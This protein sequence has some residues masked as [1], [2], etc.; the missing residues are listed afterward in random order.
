MVRMMNFLVNLIHPGLAHTV[1]QCARFCDD[2]KASHESAVKS[3]V[4]Y[5]LSSREK[6][7]R[8]KPMYGLN[9]K[10]DLNRWLE[11]YVDASFAGDWNRSWSKEP[12]SMLSRIGFIVKN[13]NCP[14]IRTSKLQTE[15]TLSSTESEYVALSH[16]LREVLPLIGLLED[17]KTSIRVSKYDKANVICKVF[18]DNEGCIELAKYTRMRPR[19]KHIAIKYHPFRGNVEDGTIVVM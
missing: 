10:P 7:G 9:M 19:T 18:E 3:M 15:I 12:S 6:E 5:L 17:I 14:I 2:P 13:A 4:R 1:H 11:V 8:E 16:V